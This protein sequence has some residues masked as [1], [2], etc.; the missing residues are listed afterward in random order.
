MARNVERVQE[1]AQKIMSWKF[2]DYA[3]RSA[4]SERESDLSFRYMLRTDFPQAANDINNDIS[5][6]GLEPSRIYVKLH[7]RRMFQ[8]AT[9]ACDALEALEKNGGAEVR[10]PALQA[11]YRLAV[12]FAQYYDEFHK[13]SYEELDPEKLGLLAYAKE[14]GHDPEKSL[15]LAELRAWTLKEKAEGFHKIVGMLKE[16]MDEVGVRI[17]PLGPRE[18]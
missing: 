6:G 17:P 4:D 9:A 12:Y 1:L 8:T 2:I 5:E 10:Q 3:D 7:E 18:R 13:L 16:V 11:A 15:D 14:M